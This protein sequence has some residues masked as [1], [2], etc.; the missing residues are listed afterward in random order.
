MKQKQKYFLWVLFAA[1]L[2]CANNSQWTEQLYPYLEKDYWWK[3]VSLG[4]ITSNVLK[5]SP[6][7]PGL[8]KC[9]FNGLENGIENRLIKFVDEFNL[10]KRIK[11]GLLMED[12]F[13]IQNE[14]GILTKQWE[15]NWIFKW[16][17][18]QVV[19]EKTETHPQII[20]ISI[21]LGRMM[22]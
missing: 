12:R 1:S 20:H 8:L 18:F 15:M 2:L 17:K 16:L 6:L 4:Y 10:L 14:L 9:F 22:I 21:K 13:S 3:R 7:V 11:T 19:K 5:G